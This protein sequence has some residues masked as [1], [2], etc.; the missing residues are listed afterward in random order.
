MTA[1]PG[2]DVPE[3]TSQAEP[4]AS[5]ETSHFNEPEVTSQNKAVLESSIEDEMSQI[6]QQN[7]RDCSSATAPLEKLVKVSTGCGPS[8]DREIEEIFAN[9]SHEQSMKSFTPL[10]EI[11][12]R[13]SKVSI[14]TS[15]PPQSTST[16]VGSAR[17]GP[18]QGER[19]IS[20]LPQTYDASPYELE[21][22]PDPEPFQYPAEGRFANRGL[23]RSH[24]FATASRFAE[25]ATPLQRSMSR[26]SFSS[27]L[28]VELLLSAPL[29]PQLKMY[30][31]TL[32]RSGLRT[33]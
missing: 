7:P 11:P 25:T 17:V 9:E 8:P 21:P 5:T 31:R 2:F 18:F 32:R 29:K 22:E 16:Q 13:S 12:S 33:S 14:G 15:P 1:E 3:L 27:E 19:F 6:R 4:A 20:C 24:S 26:Q 30:F 28:Q 23:R 10:R